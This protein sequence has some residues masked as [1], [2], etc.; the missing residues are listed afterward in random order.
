LEVQAARMLADPRA[1]AML[2]SFHEQWLE[3]KTFDQ[4]Q[5][6]TALFPTFATLRPLLKT[7]TDTFLD[8]VV[9]DGTG[10]LQTML[11]A[12]FSYVNEALAPFYGA[13]VSGADFV[14]V[15]HDP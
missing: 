12:P 14:R 11:S 2:H 5:K 15:D 8:R 3:M 7:E 9:W 4:V 1:R 13:A 6:D 10:D